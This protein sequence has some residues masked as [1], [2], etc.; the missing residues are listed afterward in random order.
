M[1]C[2]PAMVQVAATG[3]VEATATEKADVG[4]STNEVCGGSAVAAGG[5]GSSAKANQGKCLSGGVLQVWQGRPY[6]GQL[7]GEAVQPL[8]RTRAHC[9]CLRHA[10]GIGCVGDDGGGWNEG[11]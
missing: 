2:T 7:H 9:R 1:P 3:K 8:Q 4:E 6:K 5:V 11:R 10:G